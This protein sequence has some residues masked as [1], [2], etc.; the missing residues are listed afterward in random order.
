VS[1]LPEFDEAWSP[2][3]RQRRMTMRRAIEL[4]EERPAPYEIVETGS[5]REPPGTEN[6]RSDGLSTMLWS[7]LAS[8]HGGNVISCELDKQAAEIA[9]A[10]CTENT[11]IV[12]GDS[13]QSL[14]TLTE[15]IDLLYLDSYDLSWAN[16]H[17]SALHHLME[18]ASA[19]PLLKPGSLVLIDD[20]GPDGGK[21]YYAANW[22]HRIGARPI[23]RAYQYLWQMP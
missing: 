19:A 17:P 3:L 18:L 21:G 9:A 12:I 11:K 7:M 5:M 15:P 8:H 2:A 6:G 22:L 16:L 23:M 10:H 1:F 14:R 4:L 20:C 13:V